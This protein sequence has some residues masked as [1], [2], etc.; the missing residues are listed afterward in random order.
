ML[1][2]SQSLSCETFTEKRDLFSASNTG[3][4]ANS[5]CAVS[6]SLS[7]VYRHWFSGSPTPGLWVSPR[8]ACHLLQLSPGLLRAGCVC[9]D[10]LSK[11]NSLRAEKNAAWVTLT[12]LS[13]ILGSG[14]KG[15][16]WV[17]PDLDLQN[18][19]YRYK[20]E[21]NMFVPNW[22]PTAKHSFCNTFSGLSPRQL[23]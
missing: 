5:V 17:T 2:T 6:Q 15:F 22:L 18:L 11:S 20:S 9:M 12:P 19:G 23:L 7:S 4:A 3:Q 8:P 14:G 10:Q 16:Q 21:S 1:L 13:S